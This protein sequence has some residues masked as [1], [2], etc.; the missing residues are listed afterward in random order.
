MDPFSPGVEEH[1]AS[2]TA[3]E[4]QL[5]PSGHEKMESRQDEEHLGQGQPRELVTSCLL[6]APTVLLLFAYVSS[7]FQTSLSIRT[8]WELLKNADVLTPRD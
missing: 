6:Q 5:S 8:S 1:T 2:L 4:A 7:C 3:E